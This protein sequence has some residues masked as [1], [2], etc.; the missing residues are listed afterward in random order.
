MQGA[1]VG[2]SVVPKE[3]KADIVQIANTNYKYR[4]VKYIGDGTFGYVEQIELFNLSETHSGM[5]ARKLLDQKIDLKLYKERFN[6]EIL[7][8]CDCQHKHVVPIYT[9]D[10]A[11]DKPY[12][13]MELGKIDVLK[14]IEKGQLD[15]NEKLKIMTHLAKGLRHIHNKGY[16]HRDIKPNNIILFENGDYKISD[17]GLI[18]KI[19]PSQDSQVLTS[20]DTRLGNNHFMAPELMYV[21]SDYTIKSDI[22]AFGRVCEALKVT[23]VDLK[24]M[25]SR[26]VEMNHKDRFNSMDEILTI[27]ES[28][29]SPND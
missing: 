29:V 21:G 28:K 8:Q 9:F 17:F 22:F 20:I 2:L 3:V 14:L 4:T 25:V 6:R 16:L 19:Q 10:L 26:C 13:V 5:Y 11:P 23:D 1:H 27:L 7:A 18:R 24:A 15:E 12:F